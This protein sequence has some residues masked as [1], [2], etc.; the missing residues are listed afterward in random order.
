MT[1]IFNGGRPEM[2]SFNIF[3]KTHFDHLFFFFGFKQTNKPLQFTEIQF[4]LTAAKVHK[5]QQYCMH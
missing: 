4:L 3:I 1:S 5:Y 2:S